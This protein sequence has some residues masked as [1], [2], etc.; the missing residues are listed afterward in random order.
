MARQGAAGT[1]TPRAP[2]LTIIEC[3]DDPA[4]FGR[5]FQP[6][7]AW[8]A[9]RAF[10]TA[11]FGLP[12]TADQMALYRRH[13]GRAR[14]P[15]APAQEA[16]VVVG[17]RGGK[18]RIAALVAIWLACFRDYRAVLAPGEPG[19]LMVI[20]ADRRQAR[21]VFRYIAGLLDTVPMLASLVAHRTRESITLTNHVTIEV[22]T[23]SFRTIRGYT[24]IGAV[25]DELAYWSA[26]DS[27][28]PDT[29]ILAGLR[30]GMLTV[31]GALLLC[32]SSPYARRGAL[33]DAYRRHYGQDADPVLVWQADTQSMHPT[34]D[35]RVIAE[36]YAQDEPA[37][38][39]EYG[40]EFRRD[41][42]AYVTGETLAACVAPDRRALPPDFY[43]RY[44]AF[45]DPSGGS[46]D[47][48]TLG[49]AH[50]D[51]RTGKA[52][53]DVELEQRPPFSP[54]ETVQRFAEVL[55]QYRIRKVFGDRYAGAWPADRFRAHRITYEPAE[56]TKSQ[57]YGEALALLN[58]GSVELLDDKR[59]L[60]QLLS[61]ER[62]TSWGGRDS[63]DHPLNAH[64]DLAN[65]AVG[66][67]LLAWAGRRIGRLPMGFAAPVIT[68]LVPGM[69][70]PPLPV[71]SGGIKREF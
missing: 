27:A 15:A 33:W 3:L 48:M 50:L 61:L 40:A 53:L 64:D 30:P 18:S 45:C 58:S 63:I 21:V 47:S 8:C 13:T 25:C 69:P 37:A 10:L 44:V 23:A 19:T 32:I 38:C 54:D 42:E 43:T 65:C 46:H 4:L 24:L 52:V 51:R 68:E 67:L 16:W 56:K 71:P 31:K 28:N 12:M 59:L 57:L 49:I 55:E 7:S 70:P 9:W 39:A 34:V 62:R 1:S 35:A 41:L 6:T 2:V 36:A 22:H 20:A 5:A 11:L 26:E 17:R 66:A 60:S 14:P 29:E